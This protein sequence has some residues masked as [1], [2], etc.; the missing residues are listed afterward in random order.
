MSGSRDVP[1]LSIQVLANIT[2]NARA[3]TSL[4]LRHALLSWVEMQLQTMRA[5]EAIA[6]ARILE[7][8]LAVGYPSKIEAATDGEWRA[9]A[10]R[11]VRAILYHPGK[12][13]QAACM[14]TC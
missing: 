4:L 14:S 1:D 9:I 6:W 13:S 2:C 10:T 7:N 3:T 11:C 12:S 8:I 5:E